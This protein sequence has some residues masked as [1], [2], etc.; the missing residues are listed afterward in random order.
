VSAGLVLRIAKISPHVSSL[1]SN[2]S[3]REACISYKCQ[4]ALVFHIM[5]FTAAP[6]NRELSEMFM[7]TL[8]CHKARAHCGC[9]LPSV[10]EAQRIPGSFLQS[11]SQYIARVVCSHIPR[12]TTPMLGW[13][14]I[15]WDH[16]PIPVIE[17]SNSPARDWLRRLCAL[18]RAL[19][20]TEAG[21]AGVDGCKKKSAECLVISHMHHH[22]R[23]EFLCSKCCQVPAAC[24]DLSETH[25]C[26]YLLRF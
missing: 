21:A 4:S 9:G 1:S 5:F 3:R 22:E 20:L 25:C 18:D 2:V 24:K 11:A 8:K 7:I 10:C 14:W 19:L 23:G 12:G 17:S 16:Y 15:G 13:D 6:H 26:P